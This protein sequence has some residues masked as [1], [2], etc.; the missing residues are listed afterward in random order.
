MGLKSKRDRNGGSRDGVSSYDLECT[1]KQWI[2]TKSVEL[3]V[4]LLIEE[5]F[6]LTSVEAR[7]KGWYYGAVEI[8]QRSQAH[9]NN[10]FV[11]S[12]S[13]D[14]DVSYRS[15]IHTCTARHLDIKLSYGRVQLAWKYF[16]CTCLVTIFS[17]FF[18]ANRE[19]YYFSV[20]FLRS[21]SSKHFQ[22]LIFAKR[23]Q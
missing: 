6:N 14:H 22:P 8:L 19:R 12:I 9:D 4:L 13:H 20:A 10:F 16:Y 2:M 7:S 1:S 3:L 5:M 17:R 21:A 15:S 23:E 18:S 11:I